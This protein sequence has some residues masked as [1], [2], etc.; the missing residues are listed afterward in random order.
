MNHKNSVVHVELREEEAI[1]PFRLLL[2]IDFYLDLKDIFV[3]SSFRRKLV[4]ISYL[5]KLGYL[6]S[7]GNNVF[8]LS[9]NS[10][11]VGTLVNDNLYLLD[12]V[13]KA[14]DTVE[15]CFFICF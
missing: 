12:I 3:V 15:V 9:F 14:G 5:N 10:D 2:C 11:I 13:A 7:F 6:C 4:S 1:R 8:R